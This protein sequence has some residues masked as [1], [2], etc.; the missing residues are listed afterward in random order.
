MLR[1]RDREIVKHGQVPRIE[2][3][4]IERGNADPVFAEIRAYPY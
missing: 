3:R 1:T 4:E 2:Y